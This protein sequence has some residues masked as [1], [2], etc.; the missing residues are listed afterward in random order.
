MSD[1]PYIFEVTVENFQQVVLDNS[2]KCPVLVDFWAEWCN[3]CKT[4]MPLL[5]K[6]ADDYQGQFILAKVNTEQQQQLATHFQ[7][8]SIPSV[9]LFHNG[10]VV[11]EFMGAL[12]EA[13][14]RQFLNKHIPRKSDALIDQAD[15]LLMQGN[16]ESAGV[17]LKQASDN[18]PENPRIRLSYAR[19]MATLGK[20]EEAEKLL[21]ALPDDEKNKPEVVSMLAR[22]Q[23]D[24]ATADNPPA[25]VLEARL[26]D[27]PADC[28][29]LH[30]LASHKI[31]ENDYENAL[32]L[33]LTLLQKDRNYGDN[34]AQREMLRIFD[35]L[36]GQGELVKRYRNRMF[37]F[38]H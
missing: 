5:A 9:K 8:R 4:L 12:P 13:E 26:Q 30:Q 10:E 17:L 19:Y 33:L 22:I 6:L 7:I 32:E 28:E 2:M 27:N 38:L 21:Q 11:D 18:D 23:F 37:N 35:M 14:I 20:L 1:S 3:P 15:A 24:R 36:G 16:T 34:A 31:M 25:E 29:A